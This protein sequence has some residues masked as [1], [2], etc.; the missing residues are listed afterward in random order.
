MDIRIVAKQYEASATVVSILTYLGLISEFKTTKIDDQITFH[1]IALIE[2][3]VD[4]IAAEIERA[5]QRHGFSSPLE[6][7]IELYYRW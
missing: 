7:G 1:S 2:S 6:Y 3:E 4:L 5:V